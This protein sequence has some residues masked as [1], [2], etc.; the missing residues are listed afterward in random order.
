MNKQIRKV[1]YYIEEHLDDEFDVTQL[2]KVAGYSQFHFCR[3]FKTNMNESVMSYI[4]RLRLERASSQLISNNI[5]M[6][7]VALDAGYQ[8]PTGFLKAF[9]K[10]FGATPTDYKKYTQILFDKSEDSEMKNVA[11]ITR[12]K[13]YIVFTRERGDYMTSS[14]IAWTRLSASMNDLGE[15]FK[16]RPPKQELHLGK[17]NGEAIGICHD[18][19][20]ITEEANIRYDAAL[21]WGE[22]EVEILAGYG[23]ETKT[24]SSGKYA[25]TTYMGTYE[26]GEKAWNGLYGWVE[27]NN[28]KLRDEPAFEK[29]VNGFEETD[30]IKILTEIYVP[31]V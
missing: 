10:R 28:Y 11:I 18:D 15:A 30:A 24:I 5:S 9:K 17:G 31:V 27:K 8:T 3:V 19:P 22:K 13:A 14:D 21:A 1:T 7:D 20:D 25:K 16:K 29:Y 2:A 6:I 23:F 12:E 26:D 4:T